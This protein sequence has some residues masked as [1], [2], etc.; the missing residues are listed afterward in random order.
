M[1]RGVS[2]IYDLV[3][4]AVGLEPLAPRCLYS[5]GRCE[6]PDLGCSNAGPLSIE[7]GYQT[8]SAKT[9]SLLF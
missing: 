5:G 9:S 6:M 7:S 1:P 8:V 3:I 2:N 4:V